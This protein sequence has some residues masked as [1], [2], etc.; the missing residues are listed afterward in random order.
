MHICVGE[1]IIV[2]K[3]SV[4]TKCDDDCTLVH[5]AKLVHIH[6]KRS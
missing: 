4:P 1:L 5:I 3:P 2:L 6:Y